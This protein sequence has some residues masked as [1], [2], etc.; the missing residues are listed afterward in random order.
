MSG[1]NWCFTINNPTQNEQQISF[2]LQQ[3]SGYHIFQRERGEHGTEHYQGYVQFTS[4]KRLTQCKKLFPTAHWEMAKGTPQ[5]NAA[6]CS[7]EPRISET[8]VYGQMSTQG[9]RIDIEEF[10]DRILEGKTDRELIEDHA[11]QVAKFPKFI[12]FVRNTLWSP[13][14]EKP[15]VKCYYGPSGSGKTR[16]A[17][18]YQGFDN[19]YM[20]SRP[21]SGRPLWWDGYDPT[22]HTTII[23]DDF[24][25][26]V[27][28]SYLL[29]LLDRYPFQVE[30]KGGKIHFNS[31]NIF[32]T[33]NQHPDKW[34]KNVP[35]DDLTPMLRRID[36][37][38]LIE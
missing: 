21:D 11:V 20:V 18:E 25:G 2:C 27:P 32:I 30:I 31:P 8:V 28:W 16:R 13:R 19:T 29:R 33:S 35:N 22:H 14:T 4:R 15:T 6:Y 23:I 37:I 1:K 7:K 38:T 26:W 34:Y 3:V 9:A 5:Q 17:I 12:Q 24:Y 36:E 10:R